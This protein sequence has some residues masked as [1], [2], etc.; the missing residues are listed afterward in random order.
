[1]KNDHGSI[2]LASF[3]G[4][5]EVAVRH[6]LQLLVL[7]AL[8]LLL[9]PGDFGLMAMVL[10]FTAF[11]PLLC[12]FGLGMAL[13]QKQDATG[14]DET[15]VM[16]VNIALAVVFAIALLG[17]APSIAIFYSEPRVADMVKLMALSL[18][19]AAVSIVP[20]AV[21]TKR[22]AFRTRARIELFSSLAGALV[23]LFLA[24]HGYGVWS[25]AWQVLSAAATR[26]V[27]LWTAS[28]W[29]PTRQPR[30]SGLRSLL[31][32]GGYLLAANLVD[33]LYM[34]LQALLVGRFAGAADAGLYT[35]AQ[36]IPQA[37]GT[38]IGTL[39]HRIGLPLLASMHGD[40]ER[41]AAA[42]S[43]ALSA[44]M[45]VFS[46]VMV[47]I[48][49]LAEPL[50][51]IGLGPRWDG[52]ATLMVPLALAT[53]FWPWHVL[54]LVALSAAGRS[55]TVLKVEVPKKS[56]AIALLVAVSPM[57][58]EYMAWSVFVSSVLSVPLNAVPVGRLIGE[59]LTRQLRTLGPTL[60]LL[61][62]SGSAG[63]LCSALVPAGGAQ[64]FLPSVLALA[65]YG[66]GAV[67]FSHPAIN[68]LRMTYFSR[69]PSAE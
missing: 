1:M 54:N 33:T 64:A 47:C 45:F 10:A 68:E 7:L 19:L 67:L 57:G 34:R 14:S 2:R 15:A 52:T 66:V 55:D 8:A 23:A 26:A 20:D 6:V 29:R 51:S 27:M 61:L 9:E 53:L 39:I 22:L 50:V 65:V 31:G 11:G 21:L 28:G 4:A 58:V 25:L 43:R 63:L 46:P 38:F 40:R 42:F 59:G 60:W 12:D 48:A 44:T 24:F 36:T 35:M 3:W 41:S 49:L 17:A 62:A 5:V 30:F 56:M 32:F 16:A 69:R 13:I 18:P 37:P